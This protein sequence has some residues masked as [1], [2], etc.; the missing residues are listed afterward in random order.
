M[1]NLRLVLIS[2]VGR[3][4]VLSDPQNKKLRCTVD[5]LSTLVRDGAVLPMRLVEEPVTAAT[6]K[7]LFYG[8]QT[9]RS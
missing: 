2:S 9:L 5:S 8:M 6:S 1:P 4:H 7:G 3:R